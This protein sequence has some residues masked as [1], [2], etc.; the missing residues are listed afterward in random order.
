MKKLRIYLRDLVT[1]LVI[2]LVLLTWSIQKTQT[3]WF[4]P[5]TPFTG[6]VVLSWLLCY[7]WLRRRYSELYRK[8][9]EEMSSYK[10]RALALHREDQRQNHHGHRWTSDGVVSN[11]WFYNSSNTQSTDEILNP[12]YIFGEH[13]WATFL[14]I[15]VGPLLILWQ[16]LA[17]LW[18]RW[19]KS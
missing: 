18:R 17:W 4:I 11:P 2:M 5:L 12:V 9:G 13:L 19:Q 14:L 3:G 7:P 16:G 6:W 15:L 1:G 8:N 10:T